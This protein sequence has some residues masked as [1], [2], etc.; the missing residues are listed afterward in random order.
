M[1]ISENLLLLEST[2][3]CIR[4]RRK[5]RLGDVWPLWFRGMGMSERF[6]LVTTNSLVSLVA[7]WLL[8]GVPSAAL[9]DS[10]DP[11]EIQSITVTAQRRSERMQDVPISITTL[12]AD[13]LKAAGVDNL[14]GI[15]T[16]TPALR[17]DGA[18]AFAQ[19]TIRG[20]GSAVVTSGAGTNVGIYV[21]G[22][23]LPS[24]LTS[25]FELMN[26]D[27][28]QVL[29]GPQG[30]LFGHNTTG[31]AILVTTDKPS[32]ETKG[33][34]DVSYGSYNAQAY[35]GYFTTGLTENLAFDVAA[36]FKKGNGFFHD[37][38]T[39]SDDDGAYQDWAVRTGL[40]FDLNKD[41]SF[42]LRYEHT[43]T[44][45]PTTY[46]DNAY[47]VNGAVLAPG[48][49]FSAIGIPA[50]VATRP[51]DLA[52]QGDTGYSQAT[53]TVQLT[54]SFKFDFADLTSYSQW[55]RLNSLASNFDIAFTQLNPSAGVYLPLGRLTLPNDGSRTLTQEFLLSSNSEGRL[56]WT[57]GAFYLNWKDPFTAD[58]SL[59]GA[60]YVNTGHS[61]TDTLS[62]ALYADATYEV[63]DKFYVSAG[64][65]YTHDEVR[66]AYFHGFPGVP[67]TNLPDLNSNK[68]TPRLVLRYETT[69]NSSVYA[70]FSRG[71]KSAIYN[72]G[73]AQSTPIE[74]ESI[75]A[76]EV[77][78]KFAARQFSFD[79]ASYYYDY[80]N[81]QVASYKVVEGTPESVVQNAA[82]SRIYG[83]EGHVQ[84]NIASG[85]SVNAAAAYTH[86]RYINFYNSPTLTQ[87]LNPASCGAGYGIFVSG[88]ENLHDADM[89]RTPE[90]TASVGAR[91]ALPL[92]GGQLAFS[93]NEYYTSS[94]YFDSSDTY[95]QRAYILLGLRAEWTDSSNRYTVAVY[96]DNLS[97]T[98]YRTEAQN[99]NF[100]IGNVW[101]PPATFGGEIRVRF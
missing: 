3:S 79:V 41:I 82:S 17:F 61:N 86:A 49:A 91:Y 34:V 89:E 46:L 83:L 87:C 97:G 2:K 59:Q 21:D 12:S 15:A 66:D 101:G 75:S 50:V 45:D 80:K 64:A 32:Q 71:Y 51:H 65:R 31:G 68:V 18:G 90:I 78:Y 22:Y 57:A 4:M 19:A 28:V 85:F 100:G 8:T 24:P 11:D 92:A 47:V 95:E 6:T 72:V 56:K 99:T 43:K 93:G 13:Q 1:S 67:D 42:L 20:V 48:A 44:A 10:T 73:G 55:S 23:Y 40:K 60:P 63:F 88:F 77:G 84:Y 53:D 33:V 36:M 14:G 38:V 74:P 96:G 7:L 35:K 30:T 58:L 81:L 39:G 29:K 94:F 52:S 69:T 9:A 98:N 25:E 26:I 37:I 70:S 62:E 5:S 27:N 76:Y 16:V 54:S